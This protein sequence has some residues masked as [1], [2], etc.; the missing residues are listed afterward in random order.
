ML[1]QLLIMLNHSKSWSSFEVDLYSSR[2]G[3]PNDINLKNYQIL[4][5]HYSITLITSVLHKE[6]YILLSEE[7]KGFQR[8]KNF[9]YP[10]RIQKGKSC[11]RKN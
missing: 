5:I 9:I 1:K 11:L 8:I 2:L 10:R 6:S 3:L 7:D 4:V